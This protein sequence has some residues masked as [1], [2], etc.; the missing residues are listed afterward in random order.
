MPHR[1]RTI[2]KPLGVI[3]MKKFNLIF[4]RS[5]KMLLSR[6]QFSDWREIQDEYDDYMA[7]LDFE[8]LTEIEEYLKS[9]YKISTE[10]AKQEVNKLNDSTEETLEIEI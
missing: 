8:T 10:K 9:D 5:E 4:L 7:S 6:K 1:T 2:A 3:R